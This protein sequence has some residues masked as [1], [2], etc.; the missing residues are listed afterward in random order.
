MR[1][2]AR[3]LISEILPHSCCDQFKYLLV[4]KEYGSFDMKYDMCI[5]NSVKLRENKLSAMHLIICL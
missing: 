2:I 4:T 3:N 5:P 1:K